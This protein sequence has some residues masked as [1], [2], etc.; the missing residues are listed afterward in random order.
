MKLVQ[1][2]ICMLGDFAVGKTSL[3][4]RFVEGR[5]D[6][7]YLSTIGVKISRKSLQRDD[8]R[9]DFLLWDLAGGEKFI[10]YQENY[11]RGAA[12]AIIVCDLTRHETL[13]S[14]ASYRQQLKAISTSVCIVF[15]ANKLDLTE[16]RE[17]SNSELE[18]TCRALN[19]PSLLTSA[20]TGQQVEA[21]RN[22]PA[23]T[24]LKFR[25]DG[26]C[27]E[28]EIPAAAHAEDLER[29]Q[30]RLLFSEPSGL[31]TGVFTSLTRRTW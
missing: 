23:E 28:T 30:P 4:R 19:V 17:I 10:N 20:K 1:K 18:A 14:L 16:Q 3:V 24:I 6:D 9:L 25:K 2:K 15:V 12:G 29:H 31:D 8:H 21:G 7:K 11:L 27:V 22:R 13:S 5:F 26:E